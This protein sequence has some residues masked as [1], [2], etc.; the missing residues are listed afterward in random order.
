MRPLNIKSKSLFGRTALMFHYSSAPTEKA[1]MG[2][3]EDASYLGQSWLVIP[4]P[5]QRS[6]KQKGQEHSQ[7]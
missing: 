2:I 1:V 6:I 3:S 5:L 7:Q 4:E